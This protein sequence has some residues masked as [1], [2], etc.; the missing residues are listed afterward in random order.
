MILLSIG[1]LERS[2][3]QSETTEIPL[4]LNFQENPCDNLQ[5]LILY[6]VQNITLRN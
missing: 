4:N 1:Q 6:L 2:Y 3:W 5:S